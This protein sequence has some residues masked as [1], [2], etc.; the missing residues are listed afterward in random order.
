MNRP[1]PAIA[2][3]ALLLM[4]VLPALAADP[5]GDA[6][7]YPDQAKPEVDE[8]GP[9]PAQS[10][11]T[12]VQPDDYPRAQEERLT[13]LDDPGAGLFVEIFAAAM[14]TEASRGSLVDAHFGI[15]ARVT[16]DIG[17]IFPNDLLRQALFIDIQYLYSGWSDGTKEVFTNTAFHYLTIAPA[18]AFPFGEGSPYAFFLQLGGGIAVENSP[19]TVDGVSYAN[20]GVVPVFQYG[21]GIRGKPRLSQDSGLRLSFRFDVT[22]FR[23][24]YADDTYIGGGLGLGF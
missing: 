18:W 15:G 24:G 20:G 6:I 7:P 3:L 21:L 14:F 8:R 16:W 2:A 11:P 22:R 5:G 23:R 12:Y 9:L 13:D 10:D 17:R 4:P 19:L 1:L